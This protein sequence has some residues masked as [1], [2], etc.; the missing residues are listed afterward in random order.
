MQFQMHPCPTCGFECDSYEEAEECRKSH[1]FKSKLCPKCMTR[2]NEWVSGNGK[3]TTY[4][5]GN[6]KIKYSKE[7]IESEIERITEAK[8]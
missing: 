7:E 3:G 5:C 4:Y 6:C 8:P 2:M 1:E